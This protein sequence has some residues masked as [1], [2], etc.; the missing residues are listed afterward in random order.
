MAVETKKRKP[1]PVLGDVTFAAV[2]PTEVPELRWG[3]GLKSPF[4]PVYDKMYSV[5]AEGQ[6]L[7]L[8]LASSDIAK[9]VGKAAQARAKRDG[10]QVRSVVDG[11]ILWLLEVKRESE[12]R[13]TP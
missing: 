4:Q 13:A 6:A 2:A 1:M 8:E 11:S 7:R 10:R 3:K 12:A 5:F 9:T